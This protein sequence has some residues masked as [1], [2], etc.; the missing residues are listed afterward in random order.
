MTPE[1][2]TTRNDDDIFE[3]SSELKVPGGKLVSCQLTVKKGAGAPTLVKLGFYG[4]FFLHPEE[5]IEEIEEALMTA[6]LD[7]LLER[8]RAAFQDEELELVGVGVEDFVKVVEEALKKS[9]ET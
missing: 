9:R 4:D 1:N 8:T 5:K 6:G 7:E 3:Y 2:G